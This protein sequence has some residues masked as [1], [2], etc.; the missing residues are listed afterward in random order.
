MRFNKAKCKILHLSQD[1]PQDQ[2]R[3]GD[4]GIESSPE[5]KDLGVVLVHE[6]LDMS[7]QCALSPEGQLHPG[8]HLEMHGQQVKGDD[9]APL[10]CY[11][12][13]PP[14]LLCP[15]LESSAQERHGPVGVGPEEGHKNN[16][17]D[18]APLL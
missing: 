2:Y 7:W 1:N 13:T 16:Q 3:L 10:L 18:G 11:G 6:K 12:E 4:E 14:E 15:A 8:L 5:E 17:Q 9:S